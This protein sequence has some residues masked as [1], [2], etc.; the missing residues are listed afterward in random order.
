MEEIAKYGLQY[1]LDTAI[2]SLD[3]WFEQ[4]EIIDGMLPSH[5]DADEYQANQELYGD[6]KNLRRRLN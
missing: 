3:R 4:I 2:A 5:V 1:A 6:L